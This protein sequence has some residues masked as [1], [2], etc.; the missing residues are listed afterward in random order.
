MGKSKVKGI[1][2]KNLVA[3]RLCMRGLL[4][5]VAQLLKSKVDNA[6]ISCIGPYQNTLS[7]IVR[8][9]RE[10]AKGAQVRVRVQ[11]AEEGETLSD[12]F[13]RLIEKQM[14]DRWDPALRGSEGVCVCF[15][16]LLMASEVFYLLSTPRCFRNGWESGCAGFIVEEF[17]LLPFPKR[18]TPA[19]VAECHRALL[20]MVP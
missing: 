7:K 14:A 20:G 2:T 8:I 3:K 13:F 9:D 4:S 10:T 15:F 6:V 12:L 11:W 5:N 17:G 1:Q 16:S 19:R 18:L